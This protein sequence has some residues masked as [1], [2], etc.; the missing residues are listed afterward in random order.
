MTIQFP[1]Y[2]FHFL[3]SSCGCSSKGLPASEE[4]PVSVSTTLKVTLQPTSKVGRKAYRGRLHFTIL[5]NRKESFLSH[6][7]RHLFVYC[8]IFV[9]SNCSS[10]QQYSW[11]WSQIED[12]A[13]Q[14]LV[15]VSTEFSNQ[16][17]VGLSLA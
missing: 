5:S 13:F 12:L 4:L 15:L 10:V 6:I 7:K 9:C 11:S 14:V 17:I 2:T 3:Y 1:V 8:V 16:D